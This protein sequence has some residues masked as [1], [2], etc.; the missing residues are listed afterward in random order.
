M[1]RTVNN[2]DELAAALS[3]V[4][5]DMVGEMSKRFEQTLNFF[6]QGYYDSYDPLSYR[7]Q[8]DFLQSAMKI[9]PKLTGNKVEASVYID[10]EAMD[11]YYD[12][13]GYQV[14]TWANQGLH[15]GLDVGDGTPHIWDDTIEKTIGN[16]ELL[17]LAINYLR[18]KG[19]SVQVR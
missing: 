16:G 3:P 7:R 14:A 13:S 18:G 15:G 17:N 8:Y 4:M 2:M 1:A 10:T 9:E 6:L 5:K 11:N 19:I 12:A